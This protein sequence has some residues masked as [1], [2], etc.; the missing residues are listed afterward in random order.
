MKHVKNSLMFLFT[1]LVNLASLTAFAQTPGKSD[2]LSATKNIFD[3]FIWYR[4]SFKTI[5]NK[6]DGH[7][8]PMVKSI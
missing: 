6:R 8:L 4:E 5:D 7:I 3:D 1:V 2:S